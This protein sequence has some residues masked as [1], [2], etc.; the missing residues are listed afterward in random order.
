MDG[1]EQWISGSQGGAFAGFETEV[2]LATEQQHP[3]IAVLIYQNPSGL[4]A[5]RETICSNVKAVFRIK[6]VMVSSPGGP[7]GGTNKLADGSMAVA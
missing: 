6:A 7:G 5:P 4:A 1:D 3:F 2:G